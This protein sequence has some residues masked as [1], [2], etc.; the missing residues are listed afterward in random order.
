MVPISV[1]DP[2][3]LAK[4]RLLL[5]AHPL[6]QPAEDL[7]ALDAGCAAAG[8]CCCSPIRCSNGRAS[9]RSAIRCG[10]RRCSW[11]PACSAIGGC[12]LDAPDERGAAV[13]AGSAAIEV[14]DGFARHAVRRLRDQ[15]ATGSS[16][17][18]AS[19]RARRRSSPT[20]ICSTS[21]AWTARRAQSRRDARRACRASEVIRAIREVTDLSTG[22]GRRNRPEQRL[23]PAHEKPRKSAHFPDIPI[24]SHQNPIVSRTRLSYQHRL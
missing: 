5:M 24:K 3:E 8:A 4:G 16:R 17:I 20:R 2:A 10:R 7:V 9:A 11:T 15:R 13:R 12:R 18:A 21:T 14:D 23:E 6:A 1:T 19:A 22:S